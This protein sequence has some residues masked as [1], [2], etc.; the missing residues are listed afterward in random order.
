MLGDD[1]PEGSGYPRESAGS[2]GL[3]PPPTP[4]SEAQGGK[5]RQRVP[6]DDS[7]PQRTGTRQARQTKEGCGQRESLKSQTDA[8]RL[9]DGRMH[10]QTGRGG[11][12]KD[13]PR[14]EGTRG[15]A[16]GVIQEPGGPGGSDWL[17]VSEVGGAAGGWAAGKGAVPS[18]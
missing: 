15:R 7:K 9:G 6:D 4:N 16:G 13:W 3:R 2:E 14:P 18:P 10:Q 11:A 8:H 17:L 5:L 1:D 12:A